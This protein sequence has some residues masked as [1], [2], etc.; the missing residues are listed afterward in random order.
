MA[1]RIKRNV[2]ILAVT[3]KNFSFNNNGYFKLRLVFFNGYV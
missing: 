1:S 3:K 2:I